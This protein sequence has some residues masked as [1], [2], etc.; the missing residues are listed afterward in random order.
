MNPSSTVNARD[1][2]FGFAAF[3]LVS[4]FVLR[5]SDFFPEGRLFPI[6]FTS[7]SFRHLLPLTSSLSPLFGL[8]TF[9]A[10][11]SPFFTSRQKAAI[12]STV[13]SRSFRS[14]TSTVVCMYR[15]GMLMSWLGTP[16]LAL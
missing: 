14:S 15:L 11:R 10:N 7:H 5:I 8:Y 6:H 9:T 1:A 4:D 12:S 3:V 16:P 2:R 13:A